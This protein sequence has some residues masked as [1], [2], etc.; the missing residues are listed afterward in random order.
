MV[1]TRIWP[2]LFRVSTPTYLE[3]WILCSNLNIFIAKGSLSW[4]DI[5]AYEIK[6][7]S[8]FEGVLF[9]DLEIKAFDIDEKAEAEAWL[10][11]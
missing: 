7:V 8:E 9:P 3:K 11:S 1:I 4:P 2:A 5:I 6:K 10:S